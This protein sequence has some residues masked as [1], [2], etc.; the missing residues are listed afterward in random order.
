MDLWICPNSFCLF[1][2]LLFVLFY[3]LYMVT[4]CSLG[5]L[6]LTK[7][8]RLTSNHRD[9]SWAPPPSLHLSPFPSLPLCPSFFVWVLVLN[10]CSSMPYFPLINESSEGTFLFSKILQAITKALNFAWRDMYIVTNS[11]IECFLPTMLAFFTQRGSDLTKQLLKEEDDRYLES[12]PADAVFLGPK[13]VL[14]L[15]L[16]QSFYSLL[17]GTI[18]TC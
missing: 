17:T 8:T 7:C 1:V 10:L 9:V 15:W 18:F 13:M 16:Y 14:R 12:D 3:F 6:K 5:C 4:L 2:P 11:L